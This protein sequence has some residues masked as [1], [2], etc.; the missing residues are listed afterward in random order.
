[1][2]DEIEKTMRKYQPN[3]QAATQ[4]RRKSF[5]QNFVRYLL[6]HDVQAFLPGYDALRTA[7]V[8]FKP[9]IFSRGEIDELFCLS[10]WIHPNYRQQHIF[11]P[12]LFRVLYGT[13]MRISE[14][15]RLTM[16]DVNLDEKV[17]CVVDPKNHKDRHLPISGSLAEYCFWYCSKIHPAWHSNC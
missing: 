14:A 5:L 15:L 13:G 11:Y 16:E 6:N 9:Y 10:G 2:S 4:K 17:I 3:W 1:M 7:Q 12:V 8:N